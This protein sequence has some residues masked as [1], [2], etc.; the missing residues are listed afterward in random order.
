ML[1]GAEW[2][3]IDSNEHAL[4]VW[5]P[6]VSVQYVYDF[7]CSDALIHSWN[8]KGLWQRYLYSWTVWCFWMNVCMCVWVHGFTWKTNGLLWPH[9]MIIKSGKAFSLSSLVWNSLKTIYVTLGELCLVQ[10]G[11]CYIRLGYITLLPPHSG[12]CSYLGVCWSLALA[13]ICRICSLLHPYTSF[14]TSAM[15][16]IWSHFLL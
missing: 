14:Y 6:A 12:N 15:W 1:V 16:C 4:A 11:V 5:T 13:Y 9:Y 3:K 10:V 8:A 7:N 2:D